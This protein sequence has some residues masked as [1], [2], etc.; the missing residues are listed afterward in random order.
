VKAYL[1]IIEDFDDSYIAEMR[2]IAEGADIPFEDVVLNAR[3]Q[4]LK[5]AEKPASRTHQG[6]PG[7]V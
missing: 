2:G 3:T 7:L 5:L 6:L 1:P 4:L